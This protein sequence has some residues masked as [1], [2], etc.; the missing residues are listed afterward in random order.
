VRVLVD[1]AA[2]PAGLD[3][4]IGIIKDSDLPSDFAAQHEH[5]TKGTPKR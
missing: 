1:S 2:E 5:Y 3:A 4:I